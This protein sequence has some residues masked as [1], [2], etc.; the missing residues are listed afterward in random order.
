MGEVLFIQQQWSNKHNIYSM[1]EILYPGK[2]Y[3][4]FRPAV[5]YGD[6]KRERFCG[7]LLPGMGMTGMVSLGTTLGE[8]LS[9]T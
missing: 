1:Y 2:G 8:L 3:Q 4:Y 6:Y 9:S 7:W 5:L